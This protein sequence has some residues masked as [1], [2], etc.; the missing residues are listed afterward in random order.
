MAMHRHPT[1]RCD[2]CEFWAR[3]DQYTFNEDL[4]PDDRSA[5]CRRNAP[6]ATTGEFEYYSLMALW[7]IAPENNT[8]HEN[9]EEAVLSSSS[10][11]ATTG[12]DWC[13]EWQQ[14]T[15]DTKG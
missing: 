10:W 5:T 6:R 13:G 15:P 12:S 14:A 8:L 11:P 7:L 4:H 9:W 2:T 1:K 3:G